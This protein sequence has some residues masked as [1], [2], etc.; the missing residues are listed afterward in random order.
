MAFLVCGYGLIG[1]QR[2]S[3]LLKAGVE[4]REIT[5]VDPEIGNLEQNHNGIK[6]SR[7]LDSLLLK[8]Y[9]HAIVAI[10]HQ[11]AV[12]TVDKLLSLRMKVLM[13]KPMGRN[14]EEAKILANG[15]FSRNLSVG[16]NYRFMPG[17]LKL[18]ELL[19][20]NKFG[21]IHSIKVDFGHGGKPEDRLSWKLDPVTAGGGVILD[22]GIH[23]LDLLNFFFPRNIFDYRFASAVL[24]SGFWKTGIEEMAFA[25][26]EVGEALLNLSFSVVSWKT[27]FTIEI[28]GAKGYAI[29]NGRGRTD[30][31]QTLVIGPRWGW[32]THG[33][34]RD[35]EEELVNSKEDSSILHE[36]TGWINN[37]TRVATAKE[38]LLCEQIRQ[39]ILL[40]ARK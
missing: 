24:W 18:R 16:F 23:I 9:S 37:D 1:K 29:L 20:S 21:E 28:V 36:T 2:V 34:Q 19:Q 7:S 13:E 35:S 8:N 10:P 38:A 40:V 30:G 25:I 11:Y 15:V 39:E 33:S 14:L 3:A 31:P 4:P 32:K 12:N 6:T 27:R 17:V 22:P 26:G 5:I